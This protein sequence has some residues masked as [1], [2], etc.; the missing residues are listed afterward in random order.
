MHGV[1]GSGKTWISERLMAALPAIRVR[2]DLLR[3]RLFGLAESQ[4]SGSAVGEGIYLSSADDDVYAGM[5]RRAE[6]VLGERHIVILDATFLHHEQR[7][8]A[9]Q[10]AHEFGARLVFVKATA[11]QDELRRRIR[12]GSNAVQ[13]HR[14]QSRGIETPVENPRDHD[15]LRRARA[16]TIDSRDADAVA[17]PTGCATALRT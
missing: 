8:K 6:P 3:K 7:A 2:S 16:I 10:L 9:I 1:S 15:R 12:Q 4:Q 13:M 17:L 14:S 5:R 11:P